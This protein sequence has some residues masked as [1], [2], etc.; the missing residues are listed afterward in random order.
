M[1]V[2]SLAYLVWVHV[3]L[4]YWSCVYIGITFIL[5]SLHYF[6]SHLCLVFSVKVHTFLVMPGIHDR[7]PFLRLATFGIFNFSTFV[8]IKSQNM[9]QSH[10][11]NRSYCNLG[12]TIT[13]RLATPTV[14]NR[15]T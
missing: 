6:K 4:V 14:V 12:F 8:H 5:T 7:V 3:V 11:K 9:E 13:F 1:F 10:S 15:V 2:Y